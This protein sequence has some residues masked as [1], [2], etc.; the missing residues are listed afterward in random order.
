MAKAISS[1]TP[2]L[3]SSLFFAEDKKLFQRRADDLEREAER[4]ERAD[5][6]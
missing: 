1:Q 2:S 4:L 5:D 6:S 3:P